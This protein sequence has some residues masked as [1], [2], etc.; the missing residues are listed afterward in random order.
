MNWNFFLKEFAYL[1][2]N[3][4]L[5]NN[6]LQQTQKGYVKVT[7]DNWRGILYQR[8]R[9]LKWKALENEVLPFLEFQD[10]LLSFTQ[11]NLLM[12]LS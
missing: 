4:E 12:L 7:P 6:A 2:P 5:L 9:S 10:D 11:E 3:F 8:I 1:L